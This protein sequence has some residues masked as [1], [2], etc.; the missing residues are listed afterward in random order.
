MCPSGL[1]S[2]SLEALGFSAVIC[3]LRTSTGPLCQFGTMS[4]F[5]LPV[6]PPAFAENSEPHSGSLILISS[7]LLQ[8]LKGQFEVGD[9]ESRINILCACQQPCPTHSQLPLWPWQESPAPLYLSTNLS[10]SLL[11]TALPEMPSSR[12]VPVHLPGLRCHLEKLTGDG[13]CASPCRRRGEKGVPRAS[14]TAR[15]GKSTPNWKQL[16]SCVGSQ[17]KALIKQGSN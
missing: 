6:G 13:A 10:S 8:P 3:S 16:Y 5:L 9:E 12:S 4:P 1:S 15:Q 11:S 14:F 17:S 2:R 7:R